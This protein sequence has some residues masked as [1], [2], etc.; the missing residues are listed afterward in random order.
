MSIRRFT[1]MET[2]R[3][4]SPSTLYSRS[5]M[6]RTRPVS[7]SDQLLTRLFGSTRASA[8]IFFADGIP[9]P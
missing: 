6:S 5:M 4:R 8:K 1:L 2:S 3:R 7:S 9:I